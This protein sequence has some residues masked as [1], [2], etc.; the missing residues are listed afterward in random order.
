[1]TPQTVTKWRKALGVPFA[2]EGTLRF[3]VAFGKSPA[4]QPA[5]AAMHATLHDPKR[6]AKIAAAKRGKPRSPATLAKMK[7][8]RHSATSKAKMSAAARARAANGRPPWLNPG[9]SESENELLRTLSS[10]DVAKRTG[11]TLTAVYSQRNKLGIGDGRTTRHK[12]QL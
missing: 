5:L 11:R 8:H 3:K 10:A 1:M 7:R 9:W 4:T 12:R 6:A 2:N